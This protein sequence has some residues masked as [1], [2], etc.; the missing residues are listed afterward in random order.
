MA[1]ENVEEKI[2]EM[3]ETLRAGPYR[4]GYTA[5]EDI[6]FAEEHGKDRDQVFSFLLIRGMDNLIC[7]TFTV[8]SIKVSHLG[9][10]ADP[11]YGKW[12]LE[13]NGRELGGR[14]TMYGTEDEIRKIAQQY[15]EICSKRSEDVDVVFPTG[16]VM[17]ANFFHPMDELPE[18][19]KWSEDFSINGSLG[20]VNTMKWLA[21]NRGIAYGQLGNT[22]FAVYKVNDNKLYIA[23]RW[24]G[25][26]ED[27][28]PP[29]GKRVGEIDCGVW[30]FECI[31]KANYDKQIGQFP[32]DK[33][34]RGDRE[35]F[36]VNV[37]PGKWTMRVYYHHRS[38]EE[39]TEE[40]W[41]PCWAELTRKEEA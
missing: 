8:G 28:I 31:D 24:Y 17:F 6:A 27:E 30:R 1:I 19:I 12:Q 2:A 20:R 18:D 14:G 34:N 37:A 22:S 3:K 36:T 11:E 33:D 21:E 25:E 15:D 13:Y 35:S 10:E 40:F 9:L 7:E 41:F 23:P 4:L 32:A 38:E 39:L 29:P 26:E 5:E 16:K